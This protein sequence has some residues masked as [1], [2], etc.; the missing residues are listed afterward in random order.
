MPYGVRLLTARPTL[1][2]RNGLT[3]Q[4]WR[5]QTRVSL[6]PIQRLHI[7]GRVRLSNE[8]APSGGIAASE[9]EGRPQNTTV[10]NLMGHE[11]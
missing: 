10:A 8:W 11:R 7:D 2:Q 1:T 3:L 5:S 6:T 4:R 9:N